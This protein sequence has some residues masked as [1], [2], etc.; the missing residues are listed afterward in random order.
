MG[1]T[2]YQGSEKSRRIARDKYIFLLGKV[3]VE[4]YMVVPGKQKLRAA[5]PKDKLELKCFFEPCLYIL[6]SLG[7]LSN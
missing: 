4:A 3:T 7:T 5:C 2:I 1:S 6:F